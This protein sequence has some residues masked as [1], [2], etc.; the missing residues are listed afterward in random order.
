MRARDY[1]EQIRS[2]VIGIERARDMLARMR[3]REGAQTQRITETHGGSG[4]GDPSLAIIQ[5]I[6]FERRLERRIDSASQSLDDASSVLYGSDGR[7]GLA[8]LKGTRYADAICMAYL[9]AMPWAEIADIMQGS[10]RWC[11]TLCDVGFAYIDSAGWAKV[12]N[13]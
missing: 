7:G 13:A 12:K 6:D 11:H 4:D 3:E 5:R 9:Q 1:F 10:T 8:K 2:E